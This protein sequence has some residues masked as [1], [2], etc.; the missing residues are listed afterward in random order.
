MAGLTQKN[1][2]PFTRRR[3]F[4]LLLLGWI[5]IGLGYFVVWQSFL[6]QWQARFGAAQ[7]KLFAPWAAMLPAWLGVSYALT[8]RRCRETLLLPLVAL[9]VGIGLLFLLRLA[10]GADAQG[11]HHSRTLLQGDFLYAQ[12]IKQLGSFVAGWL[13]LL[14]I[15]IF[16]QDYRKLARYKYV[17]AALTILL[18]LVTTIF[19]HA[20]AQQQLQLRLGPVT[21]QPHDPVKLLLIIFMAAYLVDNKELIAFARSKYGLL[22]RMDFR[23]MGPLLLLW[24]IV[25]A[26]I[27]KHNDLGAAALLFG[28]FLGMLYI[29][30]DRKSYLVTG[31]ALLFGGGFLAFISSRT[32]QTRVNIWLDPWRYEADKG[33]QIAQSLM[34]LG[35]GRVVGA[36]LGGGY[37]ESI[38]AVQT[39]MI[40][41]AISEDL[42]LVGGTLVL[43]LFL[44]LIARIFNVAL[45]SKDRFGQ[46]LAAGLGITLAVQTWVIVA[47]TIKLIPLT[48]ITLPFIS[49][50]GTSMVVNLA[51]I[52]LVLKVSEMREVITTP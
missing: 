26:I 2:R 50:G 38:P 32:V 44:L 29:G 8:R 51:L 21:F 6:P 39:D 18:L 34:A 23:F 13:G 3:E 4:W 24:L 45:R 17:I 36:G 42:G 37:P 19:G 28:S 12:Y 16:V 31:L 35:N 30:T 14:A 47:G 10:G 41:A 5:I 20:V 52:G 9:L 11:M 43:L 49:Y 1:N 40:Y 15:I 48:G 46:L 7:W 22:S 25:M 33:H 27:F